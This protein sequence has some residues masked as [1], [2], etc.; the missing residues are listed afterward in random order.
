MNETG[1]GIGGIEKVRPEIRR[2]FQRHVAGGAILF[3]LVGII[4]AAR[5]MP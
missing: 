3:G 1:S 2:F 5:A 4:E